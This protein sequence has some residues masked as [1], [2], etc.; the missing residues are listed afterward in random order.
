MVTTPNVV[1]QEDV[2]KCV[3]MVEL[4]NIDNIGL[5]ENMA[6]YICPH[7]GEKLHVFGEGNGK[8]FAEE[9]EVTY[10]GDLP[11]QESVSDSPN[12]NGVV[13]TIEP[14]GEVSK[15]FVEI[16]E[17]IKEKFLN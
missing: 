1:S 6:Y 16:V 5:I 2:L 9:M 7:C 13:S 3:N 14:D 11:L 10:L 8:L 4:M 15:R 17:D 12:K